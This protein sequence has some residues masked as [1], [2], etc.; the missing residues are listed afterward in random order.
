[1]FNVVDEFTRECITSRLNR[2]LN[3]VDVIDILSDLFILKGVP[4]HIRSDNGPELIAK[5]L[6]YWIKAVGQTG[7]VMP[8]SPWESGSCQSFNS[9]LR[10]NF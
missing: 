3:A 8:G 7:Y 6:R 2:K 5:A 9:K 10:T 1:M 4:R